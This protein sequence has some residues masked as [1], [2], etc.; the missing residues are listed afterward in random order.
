MII[1]AL[2][3]NLSG[4]W[5]SPDKTLRRALCEMRHHNIRVKVVSQFMNSVPFGVKNQPD[6]VNA[7]AVVATVLPPDSLMRALHMIERRSGRK[8][9]KR[10][11]PRTL[12]LDLL[13]YRSLRRQPKRNTIKPLVLPHQ[14]IA[15]RDFVL[16]PLAEI[17]PGWK[18]PVTHRS[19]AFMLRQLNRLNGG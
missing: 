2:G 10:W 15:E 6:F 7:V 11:G 12:D 9:L 5:G 19:A 16:V 8:R 1:I 3:S 18:H 14:G 17:A 4:P 13:D